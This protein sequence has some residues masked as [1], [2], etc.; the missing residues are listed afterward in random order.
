MQ[1]KR[2]KGFTLIELMV[3]IGILGILMAALIPAI[4]GMI[5]RAKLR[6]AESKGR[7]LFQ[8]IQAA[9]MSLQK[10]GSK[11]VWPK[12][13]A[14]TGGGNSTKIWSK[15]YKDAREY[16]EDLFDVK[17]STNPAKQ[18]PYIDQDIDVLWG[19]GVAAPEDPNELTEDNIM[20][21]IG[22]NL[23][24]SYPDIL[25]V[26]ITRNVDCSQLLIKYQGTDDSDISVG[27]D[28]GAEYDEPFGSK[29]LVMV[30]KS[31]STLSIESLTEANYEG[32]YNKRA[33]D[34]S[35]P[36]GNREQFCYLTPSKKVTCTT[37]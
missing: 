5:T 33:F 10:R 19:Y 25:P 16:F 14:A 22:A 34:I 9:N 12:T 15:G 23:Q 30:L 28:N 32:I 36:G 17:N 27:V 35:N 1:N 31:G 21:C 29:G 26:L 20:W 37:K 6:G 2:S 24:D 4:S 13:T 11:N 7:N 18:K 8:S 3:V